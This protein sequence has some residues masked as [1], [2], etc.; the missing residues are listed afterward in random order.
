MDI[1]KVLVISLGHLS[2]DI[3]GG[4]LPTLLPYL[5]AMHNFDYQTAG[6][7]MFAYSVA[8]SIVQPVFGL[9]SDKVR[10][11][12]FAPLGVLLAGLGDVSLT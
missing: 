4:A 8:S 12:I 5:A 9:L 2:C 11:P 1:R 3:N 7:L 6:G 10:T